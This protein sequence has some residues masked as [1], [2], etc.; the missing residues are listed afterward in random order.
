MFENIRADLKQ[1]REINVGMERSAIF[2]LLVQPTTLAVINYRFVRWIRKCRIPAV[3]QLLMIV[4]M[5]TGYFIEL[6][7]GIKISA[8]AQIGPG[9]VV[10]TAHGVFVGP[11]KIGANCVVQT[12]VVIG[13]GTQRIGDNVWFGPGAKVMGLANIG[14][15]VVVIANSLVMTD[16]PD[17]TTVVGVPARIR[18]PR[19]NT[20]KLNRSGASG[21][22][23][24]PRQFQKRF[25]EWLEGEQQN[26]EKN[27]P[28]PRRS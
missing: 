28:K 18:I 5:F 1:A 13:Y 10:H 22:G 25:A 17:N 27:S 21:N 6:V 12:G 23:S 9:F 20:L 3:R 26:Q 11:A 14:S 4:G 2:K 16:V 15:N 19:G 24:R 7:T 8:T